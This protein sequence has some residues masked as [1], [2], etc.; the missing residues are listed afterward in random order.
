MNRIVYSLACLL[1]V[2]L[3]GCGET[4]EI[5]TETV[6]KPPAD[7][8]EPKVR[9][10]ASILEN[11]GEQWFFKLVGPIQTI[12]KHAEAY[13]A[14]IQSIRLTQDK[15][16]P[17]EWQVPEG[18]ES[19]PKKELRYATFYP[20]GKESG[21]ELTV[22]RFD[23]ISGVLENV[24]RWC[25]MDLG[26]ADLRERDLGQ[27]TQKVKAGDRIITLVDMTGPGVSKKPNPHAGLPPKAPRKL[28][29]E[30][31]VPE[32]WEET[33]PREGFVP[34]FSAFTVES[35]PPRVEATITRMPDR[36]SLLENVNR[37]RAQAGAEPV[38]KVEEPPAIDLNGVKGQYFDFEGKNRMLMVRVIRGEDAWYFK[39]LGDK[40]TV[41]KHKDAFER[42][43]KSVKY[44]EGEL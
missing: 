17:I 11:N 3:A 18:W 21:L 14:F 30:Y 2:S 19:G 32:E 25:R 1:A 6:P 7:S 12:S 44:I 9:L 13:A 39:L 20:G 10:L 16:K 29:I 15:D 23:R 27:Y 41:A 42:F 26:R 34:I 8:R 36:G 33:G 43:V 40:A 24:N 37:W 38:T 35:G 28:P 4:E 5:R 22:S 31:T